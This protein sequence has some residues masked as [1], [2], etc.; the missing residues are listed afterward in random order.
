VWT[1]GRLLTLHSWLSVR[2]RGTMATHDQ[3]K[4]FL[5]SALGHQP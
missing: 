1:R 4:A 2:T 5:A 3:G